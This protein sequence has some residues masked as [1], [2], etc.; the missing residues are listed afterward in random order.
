MR[1]RTLLL[2]TLGF[3]TAGCVS[4]KQPAVEKHTYAL[5]AAPA[6]PEPAPAGGALL[7]VR[8]FRAAPG[9]RDAGFVYRL[10][11]LDYTVDFYNQFLA[12]PDE[13][14]AEQTARFLSQTGLFAAVLD[15]SSKLLPDYY[16]E[17][18]LDALYGD[19]RE[20]RSPRAVLEISFF[21]IR[22]GAHGSELSAQARFREEAPLPSTHAR[23]LAAGFNEALTR[24]LTA[25]AA[26]LSQELNK[27][28]AG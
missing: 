14:L 19:F 5:E 28:A 23:D 12:G 11:D 18:N 4:I 1:R 22:A 9:Y 13:M 16:L 26:R 8:R 7:R 21:L 17:G 10:G 25:L 15:G 6:A 3:L 24:V 20:R 2:G 27:D